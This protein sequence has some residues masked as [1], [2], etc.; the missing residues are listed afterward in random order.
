[1]SVTRL[2]CLFVALCSF[3]MVTAN[4]GVMSLTLQADRDLTTLKVGDGFTIDVVLD[5]MNV[6]DLMELGATVEWTSG[7][8]SDPTNETAGPIVPDPLDLFLTPFSS[9]PRSKPAIDG[10]FFMFATPISTNGT[11]FSFDLTA[12]APGSG[13]IEFD[14]FSLE[15][16][17]VGFTRYFED[18]FDTNSLPFN[19]TRDVNPV[20]EPASLACFAMIAAAGLRRRLRR[21]RRLTS[22]R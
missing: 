9:P 11:F 18:D 22:P 7:L 12:A 10:L 6:G 15:A 16:Y 20:P 8:L 4:A 14:Y 1:M 2:T 19:I 17:D 21:N 13:T 5:K 3:S